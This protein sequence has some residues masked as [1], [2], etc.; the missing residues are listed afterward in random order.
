MK[1]IRDEGISLKTERERERKSDRTCI[2]RGGVIESRTGREG[3]QKLG[4]I[5]EKGQTE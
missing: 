1:E 3:K 2:D 5:A 4:V